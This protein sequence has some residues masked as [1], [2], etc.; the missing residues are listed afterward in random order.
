MQA[1]RDALDAHFGSND[2]AFDAWGYST[3]I[4]LAYQSTIKGLARFL[5]HVPCFNGMRQRA[6][7]FEALPPALGAL[8]RDDRH[9]WREHW[10]DEAI[11]LQSEMVAALIEAG[12]PRPATRVPVAVTPTRAL[13]TPDELSTPLALPAQ[14]SESMPSKTRVSNIATRNKV[15]RRRLVR[16]LLAEGR[17]RQEILDEVKARNLRAVGIRTIDNDI[18]TLRANLDLQ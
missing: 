11:A 12:I 8:T 13:A 5:D 16:E 17:T 15:K 3:E 4:D 6:P 14:L 18:S 7:I 10:R 9:E 1:I 2:Y